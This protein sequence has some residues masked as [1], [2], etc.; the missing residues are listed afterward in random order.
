MQD[1]SPPHIT[2]PVIQL[3]KKHFTN[4]QYISSHCPTA[5]PPRLSDLNPYDFWLLGYLK[6]VVYSSTIANLAELK[7][8]IHNTLPTS[9][10]RHSDLLWNMFFMAFSLW[11]RIVE[12]ILNLSAAS[13]AIFNRRLY[14]SV[15]E[16]FVPWIDKNRI[17]MCILC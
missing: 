11:W 5:F 17:I 9:L 16:V 10:L 6:N 12:R 1:G 14:C 3:I 13:L 15:Y 7:T 4:N 8:Q 2:K